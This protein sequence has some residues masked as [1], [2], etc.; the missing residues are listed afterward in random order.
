VSSSCT[1]AGVLVGAIAAGGA[2]GCRK[3]PSPSP[4]EGRDLGVASGAAPSAAPLPVDRLAPGELAPGTE[5]VYGLVLPRGMKLAAHFNGVAHATGPVPAEDVANYVRDRVDARRVEL[6]VVGT[7]FPAV[8]VAAGDPSRVYR[9]E[10]ISTGGGTE[11]V[12]RDVT[13][14]PAPPEEP[15]LSVAERWRRAGYNPDG[16]PLDPMHLR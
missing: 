14:I 4:R 10:V 16:T 11:L 8:H 3:A 5:A 1:I 2:A 6:G 9:I 15:G 12:M 13:P 7:V